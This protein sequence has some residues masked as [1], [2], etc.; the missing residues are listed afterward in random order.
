MDIN[1]EKIVEN[2]TKDFVITVDI[3]GINAGS[4]FVKNSIKG[5]NFLIDMLNSITR[6]AHEQQFIQEAH[7]SQK[8]NDTISVYPQKIFNSYAYHIYNNYPSGLDAYGN[9][10]RWEYGD[11]IIHFPGIDFNNRIALA[12]EYLDKVINNMSYLLE[13]T[14]KTTL[15]QNIQIK[16]YNI[17]AKIHFDKPQNYADFII[18]QINSEQIYLNYLKGNNLIILDI[19]ANV[20]LFS[21][22]CVD[23]AQKI[24]SFESYKHTLKSLWYLALRGITKSISTLKY[25]N[26]KQHYAQTMAI[27]DSLHI[28][29][30]YS[31]YILYNDLDEYFLLGKYTDF[32]DLINENSD[33]DIFVFKNRF[34]KMGNDLIKYTDFNKKFNLS[35][36]IEGNYWDLYREKNLIKCENVNVMGIHNCFK[37]FSEKELNEIVVDQFYHIINFE[38]KHREIL[39]TEYIR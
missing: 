32:N 20:G 12:N 14:V 36:I 8:Y 34:C 13:R 19:G 35:D 18:N 31:K 29:K 9:N 1:L 6:C 27:N 17:L 7:A 4:F 2:E 33:I 22:H 23:C 24:Y 10:G 25:D 5:K 3:N 26:T 21:L 39:M 38:E 16:S 30:N 37:D 28:L 15:G 11:F